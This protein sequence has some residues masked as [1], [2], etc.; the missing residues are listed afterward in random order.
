MLLVFT[1]T[2]VSKENRIIVVTEICL[3]KVQKTCWQS[4]G[5]LSKIRAS[6][7][8]ELREL[9]VLIHRRSYTMASRLKKILHRKS[10]N[11]QPD[12]SH[13]STGPVGAPNDPTLRATPYDATAPA[14]LPETGA[15]PIKGDGSSTARQ[16]NVSSSYTT[17]HQGA[18]NDLPYPAPTSNQPSMLGGSP[19]SNTIP[20]KD[21]P[22]SGSYTTSQS[23]VM[24]A[25]DRG[26]R[27]LP[28]ET[29]LSQDLLRLNFGDGNGQ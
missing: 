5:L 26:G 9:Q 2:T 7:L 12:T 25:R 29:A 6:E 20:R 13:G 4:E 28:S 11:F 8:C 27:E 10:Q 24:P 16:E 1:V 21:R 19:Y 14:S 17:G 15:Y 18:R 23:N 3:F 22:L